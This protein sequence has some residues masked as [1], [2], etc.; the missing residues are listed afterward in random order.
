MGVFHS[1]CHWLGQHCGAPRAKLAG[2]TC[3]SVR[4]TIVSLG[5][6]GHG[7]QSPQRPMKGGHVQPDLHPHA[8]VGPVVMQDGGG[9]SKQLLWPLE[10][11]FVLGLGQGHHL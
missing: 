3:A 8:T 4:P 5:L 7:I 1:I 2:A 11:E 10:T 6:R 9:G